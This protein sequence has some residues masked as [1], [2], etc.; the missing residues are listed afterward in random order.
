[1]SGSSP[2][3]D[4]SLAV[5]QQREQAA[6]E[7]EERDAAAA[8][9]HKTELA[10]L[11]GNARTAAGGDVRNYFT[12]Q[13]LDPSGYGGSIDAQLNNIL[14]SISPTEENPGAAFSGAG[15]TIWDT[16]QT[17]ARAKAQKDINQYFAPNFE[18][19]KA[20]TTLDDPYW[21]GYAEEQYSDADAIIRNMLDRGVL[22]TSG[23]GAAKADL[24]KQRSGVNTR[25]DLV[26]NDLIGKEQGTL[27]GIANKAR[28]TASNLQLGT[29]F[30]PGQYKTEADTEFTNF[31][32]TLGDKIR[33]GAPGQLFTTAGLAAIGGAGQGAGN[34]A[35]N[36]AAA[37]GVSTDDTTDDKNKTQST[38]PNTIF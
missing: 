37:S 32:N 19:S 24:D 10:T 17:G 8:A 33:A 35:F 18:T 4:N 1:M 26:G 27:S 36:P 34:T 31:L 3:P 9:Q 7:K 16:L 25:L 29:D 22:T 15:Q 2:P 30:D 14:N 21:K 11:R 38:N 20:P 28:Q 23:Y 12:S 5:E 6:R 13:G